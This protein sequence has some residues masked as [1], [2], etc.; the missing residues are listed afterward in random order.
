MR[1]RQNQWDVKRHVEP[2]AMDVVK[3]RV[4]EDVLVAV[5]EDVLIVQQHV[6]IVVLIKQGLR[7]L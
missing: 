4:Q 7:F 1:S 5:K 6:V 3:E 2:L